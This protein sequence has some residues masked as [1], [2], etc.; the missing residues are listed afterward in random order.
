MAREQHQLQQC[1]LC[2]KSQ[3]KADRMS[4]FERGT[5][6]PTPEEW[7][8]LDAL[9]DLGCYQPPPDE[10]APPANWKP[11]PPL[12]C[13]EG[14]KPLSSRVYAARCTFGPPVDATFEDVLSRDDAEVVEHFLHRSCLDSGHEYYFWLMLLGLGGLPRW[15]SPLK[16]GYRTHSIVDRRTG[17]VAGDL[18]HPCLLLEAAGAKLLLFPQ[19]TLQT[20]KGQYRLDALVCVKVGQRRFWV[21]I[22]IDGGG[23][24]AKFD[25]QRQRILGLPTLRFNEADLRRSDFSELFKER[26]TSLI[27]ARTG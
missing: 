4:R 26:M 22:E 17:R 13:W 10:P 1:T 7:Q 8:R 9:L 23:H 20:R 11:D 25:L 3:I 5:R 2:S 14:D 12:L 19:V 24:D 18:R 15:F 21:D 6:Y 16:A 27:K